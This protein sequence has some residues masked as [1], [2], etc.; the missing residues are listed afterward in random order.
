MAYGVARRTREIGIR[1]ALGAGQFGVLWMVLRESL[2]LV[3]CAVGV[4]LHAAIL[5]NRFVASML[6]ACSS[7]AGRQLLAP[8]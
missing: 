1:I 6:S 8:C 7:S 4:G 3:G 2:L 5:L